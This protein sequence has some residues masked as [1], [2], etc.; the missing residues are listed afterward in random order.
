VALVGLH[1]AQI[2]LP[3]ART[4]HL[5]SRPGSCLLNLK[6]Q[7]P[8]HNITTSQPPPTAHHLPLVLLTPPTSETSLDEAL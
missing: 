3:V 2:S 5:G 1:N 7:G 4:F 8:C 6:R